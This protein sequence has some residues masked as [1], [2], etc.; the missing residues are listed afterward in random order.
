M[1]GTLIQ[2][3]FFFAKN[4]KAIKTT[5]N[6][7]ICLQYLIILEKVVKSHFLLQV[8]AGFMAGFRNKFQDLNRFSCN[9]SNQVYIF[10]KE[11]RAI[12]IKF[13]SCPMPP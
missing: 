2:I 12:D 1:L 3:F 5:T 4:S 8:M 13:F 7:P 10:K 9:I 6:E 11:N